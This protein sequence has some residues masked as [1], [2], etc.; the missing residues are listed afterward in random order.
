MR[1]HRPL[2]M[3]RSTAERL[4]DGAA[5]DPRH[6]PDALV[7]LLA[8]ARATAHPGELVGE[9]T[10]MD[11]FRAAHLDLALQP[12][13]RSM[14]E[15]A[16][17]KLLT[18]KVAAAT[19]VGVAATGG[20]ALAAANGVLP[21][22]LNSGHGA[23]PSTHASGAASVDADK[24]EAKGSPSP[25]LVGLCRA[26]TAGAGDNPGK[27]LENPAFSVLITTAGGKEEVAEYCD[28]LLAEQGNAAVPTDRPGGG[29]ATHPTG[30]PDSQPTGKPDS[31]PPTGR[32]TPPPTAGTSG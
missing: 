28:T 6:A 27:A 15:I 23:K 24:P 25:S 3:D 13:R 2:R 26:F 21:N 31:A 30:K 11:A 8:A 10:I 20:V 7:R 5:V 14:L 9:H 4:L 32:R 1:K 29:P 16:L 18:L 12:R 19:L 17:A 22:P